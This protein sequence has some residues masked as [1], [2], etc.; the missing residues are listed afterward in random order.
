MACGPSDASG[1]IE[2]VKDWLP[3]E[4]CTV[5]PLPPNTKEAPFRFV[6]VKNT[7]T[8]DPGVPPA[9]TTEVTTGSDGLAT[10][11]VRFTGNGDLGVCT[12]TARAVEVVNKFD[13]TTACNCVASIKVVGKACPLTTTADVLV[14]P[15]PVTIIGRSL[16]PAITVE[17]ATDCK[18]TAV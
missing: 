15:L 13:G 5:R 10:Y 12:F 4:G 7:R 8:L 9:D 17:G 18:V 3:T 2:T 14:K 16:D 6:P 1:A 11:S